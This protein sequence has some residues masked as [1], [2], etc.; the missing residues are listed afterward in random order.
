MND[1]ERALAFLLACR[2]ADENRGIFMGLRYGA[3]V[4]LRMGHKDAAERLVKIGPSRVRKEIDRC[5]SR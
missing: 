3:K 4:L 1:N 2:R 5:P